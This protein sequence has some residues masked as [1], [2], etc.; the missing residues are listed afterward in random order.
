MTQS[1]YREGRSGALVTVCTWR[2]WGKVFLAMLAAAALQVAA[3]EPAPDSA[4]E[5][6]IPQQASGQA[7]PTASSSSSDH[8]CWHARG[9]EESY[10]SRTQDLTDFYRLA[11]LLSST[12]LDAVLGSNTPSHAWQDLTLG[13]VLRLV[14]TASEDAVPVAS[15]HEL[16]QPQGSL[17]HI[18]PLNVNSGEFKFLV[19]QNSTVEI[20]Q[21]VHHMMVYFFFVL[22]PPDVSSAK[23]LTRD[24]L[25][26]MNGEFSATVQIL[27]TD[28]PC[29]WEIKKIHHREIGPKDVVMH[30]HHDVVG[31]KGHFAM[32]VIKTGVMN[33]F[34]VRF[35]GTRKPDR[36]NTITWQ[37]VF[38]LHFVP[39]NPRFE[40]GVVVCLFLT[41]CEKT[42]DAQSCWENIRRLSPVLQS[43]W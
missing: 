3:V 24:V 25:L 10:A 38:K 7:S 30:L 42:M 4:K 40:E 6:A 33:V 29:G 21:E 14:N 43:A 20:T 15:I 26:Q 11:E 23:N 31:C 8:A 5:N 41:D 32:G 17:S 22:G 12:A 1:R 27:A 18:Q 35:L 34:D 39:V 37:P 36:S 28:T 19:D 13:Q 9:F 16:H 2:R